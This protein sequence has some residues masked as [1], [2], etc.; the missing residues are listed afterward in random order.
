MMKKGCV[1]FLTHVREAEKESPRIE[2]IR[3]VR[4]Y[5]DVF[6]NDLLGLPPERE[7][8]FGIELL[9]GTKPISIPPYRMAPI[10]LRELKEQLQDLLDK[11]F[12]RPSTSHW[13]A[14][15]LFVKKKDG[16]LQLC[17]NYR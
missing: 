16:F 3:V 17:I 5:P 13:G 9:L 12:I 1:T 15:V 4:E 6:P 11:K 8:K 10:E 7:V 14:L 2:D